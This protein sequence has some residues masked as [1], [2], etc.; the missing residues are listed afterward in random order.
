[1][2]NYKAI[3]SIFVARES[4]PP[5]S[6]VAHPMHSLVTKL[7]TVRQPRYPVPSEFNSASFLTSSVSFE[8]IIRIIERIA[9]QCL[10]VIYR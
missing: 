3:H 6:R 7:F 9:S 2:R 10:T 4:E 5:S 1:M 8:G